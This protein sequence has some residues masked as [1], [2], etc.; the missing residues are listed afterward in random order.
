MKQISARGDK[1]PQNATPGG[2]L[3]FRQQ[4]TDKKFQKIRGKFAEIARAT[5]VSE[6]A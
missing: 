6:Y 2:I 3:P 5:Y 4:A 1:L